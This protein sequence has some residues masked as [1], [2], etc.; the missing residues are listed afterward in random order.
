MAAPMTDSDPT[1]SSIRDDSI[2]E[3]SL[4]P[5]KS[6]GDIGERLVSRADFFLAEEAMIASDLGV[7]VE[8]AGV[9]S[10][11]RNSDAL[12]DKESAAEIERL[13]RDNEQ[14]NFTF[15]LQWEAD[16]R[17]I[18]AWQAAHPG[19]DRTWP[20]RCCMVIW[21]IEELATA[22]SAVAAAWEEA[23]DW[24][25]AQYPDNANTNAFCAALRSHVRSAQ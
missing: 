1:T 11:Y 21:L 15:D 4:N 18:K 17:A 16:Q 9:V 10:G 6:S 12:L 19:K 3:S 2:C 8:K 24:L 13:R 25:A 14:L 20:D 7:D 22:E 5:N 23:A